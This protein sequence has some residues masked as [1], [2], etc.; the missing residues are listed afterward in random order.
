MDMVA[1]GPI[2]G[3]TPTRVPKKTPT[4]QKKILFHVPAILSPVRKFPKNSMIDYLYV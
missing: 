2:P 1:N 3:R 4:K